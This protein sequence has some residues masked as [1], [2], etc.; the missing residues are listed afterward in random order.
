VTLFLIFAALIVVSV[1]MATTYRLWQ[2][3]RQRAENRARIRQTSSPIYFG[4]SGGSTKIT[5]IGGSTSTKITFIH[6]PTA[7]THTFVSGGVYGTFSGG[8]GGSGNTNIQIPP[9][10]VKYTPPSSS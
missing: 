1:A 9:G 6:T 5:F 10:N 8:G 3:R 7:N 2:M 4:G